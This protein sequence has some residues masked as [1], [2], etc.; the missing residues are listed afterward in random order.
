MTL[1]RLFAL[2]AR[3]N[4]FAFATDDGPAPMNYSRHDM[5]HRGF[6][7]LSMWAHYGD[8]FRGA[9]FV[10]DKEKLV[11]AVIDQLQASSDGIFHHGVSYC[12]DPLYLP[13]M[14]IDEDPVAYL[15][16]HESD[17]LSRKR[18]QWS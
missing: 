13:G 14:E 3:V 5:S 8:R 10:F 12:E 4:R 2:Q 18:Q 7:S 6:G 1:S 9:C 16:R 15:A 11:R 17:V